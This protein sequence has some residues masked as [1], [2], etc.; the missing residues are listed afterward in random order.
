MSR[1]KLL[2]SCW[3]VH[4][5]KRFGDAVRESNIVDRK[6]IDVKSFVIEDR[7]GHQRPF[8]Y[9]YEYRFTEYEYEEGR[10]ALMPDL[11]D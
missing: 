1:A 2:I 9:E 5:R 10:N 3:S 6:A 4:S 7:F 11:I 8:E